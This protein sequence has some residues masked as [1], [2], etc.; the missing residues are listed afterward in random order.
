MSSFSSRDEAS[1]LCRDRAGPAPSSSGG[2]GLCRPNCSVTALHE[3]AHCIVGRYL[4][5]PIAVVTIVA[6]EHFFGR[7]L[8]P[9]SEP[10]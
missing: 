8:G 5:L 3:S 9:A 1:S 2:A 4:G 7:C 10:G 6:S